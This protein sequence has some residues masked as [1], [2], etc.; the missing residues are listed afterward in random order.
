MRWQFILSVYLYV[1]VILCAIYRR[2]QKQRWT[3]FVVETKSILI[4]HTQKMRTIRILL[5]WEKKIKWKNKTK[6]DTT[7][8]NYIFIMIIFAFVYITQVISALCFSLLFFFRYTWV[9][10]FQYCVVYACV[11][12]HDRPYVKKKYHHVPCVCQ[13]PVNKIIN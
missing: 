11:S 13:L 4:R 2:G 1:G 10:H 6:L 8:T 12:C 7:H 5:K 9:A 3:K